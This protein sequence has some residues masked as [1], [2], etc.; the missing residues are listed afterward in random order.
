MAGQEYE[1]EHA[2]G[3]GER[4]AG[5]EG[6]IVE[7]RGAGPR[8]GHQDE[9][10]TEPRAGAQDR[11]WSDDAQI[12]DLATVARDQRPETG[13]DRAGQGRRQREGL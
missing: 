7:R 4:N 5:A 9:A 13:A 2:K 1:R 3:A 11:P 12:G 10:V 6:V 8:D